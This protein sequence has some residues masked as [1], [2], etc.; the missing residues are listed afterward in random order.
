[1]TTILRLRP[2]GASF[3]HP[4]MR[5]V[6]KAGE[7]G[8]RQPLARRGLDYKT[9]ALNIAELKPQIPQQDPTVLQ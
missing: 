5:R 8:P 7:K 3:D 4:G 2:V 1:M 9:A 6:Q